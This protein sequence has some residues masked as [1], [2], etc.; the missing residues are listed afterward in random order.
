MWSMLRSYN[1]ESWSNED[2]WVLQ[3]G[4]RRDGM[5]TEATEA[6]LLKSI[7]RKWLVKEGW[8]DLAYVLMICKVCRSAIAL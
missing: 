1:Q 2:R 8:E 6:P 4:L 5:T 3:G 7:T